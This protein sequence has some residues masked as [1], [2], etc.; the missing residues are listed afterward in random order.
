MF[1]NRMV[2]AFGMFVFAF[3][4]IP[5]AIIVVTSFGNKSTIQFPISGFTLKW[6]GNVFASDTFVSAFS[7]SFQI[8]M[9]ATVIAL[10]VGIPAAYALSRYGIWGKSAIKG[11]FLSPAI[12]PG[13][14]VGYSLF[15]FL[16]VSLRFPI[17]QGLL[18][19]HFLISVP[20]VIRVVGSSLDQFD[21]STEEAAWTL[22]CNRIKAF[23]K[24]VLPNISSGIIASFLLAFI[25]SFNNIP[26][27]MFLSGPGVKL[28]PV[29]LMNYVEYYYDPTVSALSVFLMLGTI[30][31]MF[32]IEKTMG[33]S[34]ISK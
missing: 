1:K 4:F 14:V 24:V 30:I 23:S 10:L 12:V 2:A 31:L 26:L 22:G 20:Y 21:V 5:L 32:V 25:N 33:I 8:A 18:V 17:Y 11:F 16:V 15:Q 13:V 29:A 34:S 27:S 3:L 28:L 7:L 9:L 19:G 6:Y